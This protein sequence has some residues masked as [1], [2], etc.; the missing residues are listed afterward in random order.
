MEE[1][2][3]LANDSLSSQWPE[4]DLLS[5]LVSLLEFFPMPTAKP[6]GK[7]RKELTGCWHVSYNSSIVDNQKL[8]SC[9]RLSSSLP[10]DYCRGRLM[11]AT[12]SR[13]HKHKIAF[14]LGWRCS[15]CV[16]LVMDDRSLMNHRLTVV[17]MS[18]LCL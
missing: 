7:E 14:K 10:D 11:I 5:F 4:L 3:A 6:E 13:Q 1:R 18:S 12:H 9:P 8:T 16:W 15:S 2:R 17:H